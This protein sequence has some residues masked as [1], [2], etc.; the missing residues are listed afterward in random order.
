MINNF[1][2]IAQ[3]WRSVISPEEETSTGIIYSK[4]NSQGIE[5]ESEREVPKMKFKSHVHN[6]SFTQNMHHNHIT[7]SSSASIA[8]PIPNNTLS[9][10]E[11]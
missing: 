3:G 1:S 4:R 6:N 10:V 8:Y 5:T 2:R 11:I 9:R 7:Y